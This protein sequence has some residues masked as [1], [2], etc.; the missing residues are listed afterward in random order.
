MLLNTVRVPSLTS[1]A[2]GKLADI[3][4]SGS[5]FVG[6]EDKTN[7]R[8]TTFKMREVDQLKW[9]GI[10]N[11]TKNAQG[12]KLTLYTSCVRDSPLQI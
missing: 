1:R 7:V 6:A 11:V 10:I 8:H 4:F 9:M 12:L 3:N 5:C 2:N